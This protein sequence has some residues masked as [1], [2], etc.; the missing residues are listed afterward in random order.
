MVGRRRIAHERKH[1]DGEWVIGHDSNWLYSSMAQV[2][3]TI[4]AIVGGF[5]TTFGLANGGEYRRTRCRTLVVRREVAQARAAIKDVLD[6]EE[7]YR[8]EREAVAGAA[9]LEALEEDAFEQLYGFRLVARGLLALLLLLAA[10]VIVPLLLLPQ[11][12]EGFRAWHRWAVIGG[13]LAGLLPVASF[14]WAVVDPRSYVPPRGWGGRERSR[15]LRIWLRRDQAW[16]AHFFQHR[17]RGASLKERDGTA[18]EGRAKARRARSE[19]T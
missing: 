12:P 15:R 17:D 2:S 3:A 19:P 1:D 13:F 9:E 18:L 11:N 16:P 6:P 5:L 7:R 8:L 14:I 4:V 10:G